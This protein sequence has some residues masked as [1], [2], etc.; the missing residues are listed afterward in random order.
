MAHRTIIE[1]VGI[2]EQF[3]AAWLLIHEHRAGPH[4]GNAWR[5]VHSV[6]TNPSSGFSDSM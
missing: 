3:K 4:S 6:H 5:S 2:P 1:A